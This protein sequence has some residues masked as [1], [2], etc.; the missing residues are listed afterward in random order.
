MRRTKKHLTLG[1]TALQRQSGESEG[2]GALLQ[3]S[4]S[5]LTCLAAGSATNSIDCFSYLHPA[6]DQTT[7]RVGRDFLARKLI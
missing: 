5:K 6:N 3:A 1:L 7:V 4:K 2:F